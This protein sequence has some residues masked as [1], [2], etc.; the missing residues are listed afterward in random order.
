[1]TVHERTFNADTM[2]RTLDFTYHGEY[3]VCTT[4][5]STKLHL[6]AT[7]SVEA[8]WRNI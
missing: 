5:A 4:D 3:D 6:S 8:I 7:P 2:K 1:V